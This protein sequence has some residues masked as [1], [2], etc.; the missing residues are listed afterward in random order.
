MRVLWHEPVYRYWTVTVEFMDGAAQILVYAVN[1]LQARFVALC[2]PGC[3]K[4]RRPLIA[5]F[6]TREIS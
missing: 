6:V 5:V 3:G 2:H 4:Y 1:R